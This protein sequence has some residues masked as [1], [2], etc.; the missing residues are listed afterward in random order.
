MVALTS[1][2]TK[3]HLKRNK[4]FYIKKF[5]KIWLLYKITRCVPRKY[6]KSKPS[7]SKK[8]PVFFYLANYIR[9]ADSFVRN[10]MFIIVVTKAKHLPVNFCSGHIPK[11][12]DHFPEN[13]LIFSYHIV[14]PVRQTIILMYFHE[15]PLCIFN[16]LP[17]LSGVQTL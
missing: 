6:R 10:R 7:Y 12:K 2:E 11:T 8:P 9:V 16:S 4:L 3:G 15:M 14:N 5:M 1:W 13:Y 17:Y